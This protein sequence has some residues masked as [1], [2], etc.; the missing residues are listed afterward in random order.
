[1]NAASVEDLWQR[2]IFLNTEN[3]RSKKR[4]APFDVYLNLPPSE[5]PEEH[6]ELH[7]G[8]L[9][10][11]G[12][13]E[14]SRDEGGHADNGLYE[15]F[16]ITA[17]YARLPLLDGWDPH[18]LTVTFIPRNLAAAPDIEVGRVSLYFA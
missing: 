7:A 4:S 6:P 5:R 9:P 8:S 14:A 3:I 11:F 16:D 12:L 13:V 17:L 15:Q 2:R 1:L 10:M 18:S